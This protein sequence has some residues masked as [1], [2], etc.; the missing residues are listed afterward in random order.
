[1]NKTFRFL[2]VPI[3]IAAGLLV[4]GCGPKDADIANQAK[5]S[6]EAGGAVVL[7]KSPIGNGQAAP[8]S[9]KSPKSAPAATTGG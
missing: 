6:E 4:Q 9:M 7:D 5:K 8:K 2:C 3:L 1:M